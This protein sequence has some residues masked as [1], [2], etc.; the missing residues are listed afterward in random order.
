LEL[1]IPA[2]LLSWDQAADS[3]NWPDIIADEIEPYRLGIVGQL[4]TLMLM[5]LAQ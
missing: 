3:L 5:S 1:G 2:L 4:L